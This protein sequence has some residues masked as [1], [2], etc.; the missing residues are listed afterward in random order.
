MKIKSKFILV[1]LLSLSSVRSWA[2]QVTVLWDAVTTAASGG[3]LSDLNGYRV[4]YATRSYES[5]GTFLS[6]AAA[7]ADPAVTKLDVSPSAN[8]SVTLTLTD[9]FTYYFRVAAFD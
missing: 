7:T 4:F 8:P 5:G 6:T 9:G 2:G 1:L 3:S